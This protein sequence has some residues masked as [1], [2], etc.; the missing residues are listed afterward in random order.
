[1]ASSIAD[2]RLMRSSLCP[3]RKAARNGVGALRLCI[4][5]S[6]PGCSPRRRSGLK[7]SPMH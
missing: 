1:M 5:R 4:G 3:N 7:M 6:A 2:Q